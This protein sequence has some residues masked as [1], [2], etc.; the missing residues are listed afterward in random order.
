MQEIQKPGTGNQ[1]L[2]EEVTVTIKAAQKVLLSH[3]IQN[4]LW[5]YPAYLGQHFIYHY[6]LLLTWMGIKEPNLNLDFLRENVLKSQLADGSWHQCNDPALSEGDINVTIFNYWGLKATGEDIDSKPMVRARQFILKKGGVE[7]AAQFTKIILCLFQNLSWEVIPYSPY[8]IFFE[9][10]MMNYRSFSQ[11][12][13]PHMFGIAYMRRLRVS[14]DFGP[15]FALAEL[16][17]QP[18][19][20]LEPLRPVKFVD[21]YMVDKILVNQQPKGS[22]GGYTVATCFSLISLSNYA[23]N[24]PEEN[25]K[26]ANAKTKGLEMLR[27]LYLESGDGA[28][29]GHLMDSHYWDTMLAGLALVES[30]YDK[31]KLK[32]AADYIWDARNLENGG[33][34]FGFDFEYAPDIDDTSEALLFCKALNYREEDLK[35]AASW[36][37]EC[38]SDDGGWGAFDKNNNGN[39]LLKYF[40]KNLADS[41]ALFDYS[42]PDTTGN[43]MEAL[44]TMGYTKSNSATQRHA[45]KF[46]KGAQKADGS[47]FGRW[48]IN[49]I[50]GTCCAISGLIRAG[51]NSSEPYLQKSIHWFE[52]IQNSD[53]GWGESTRSYKEAEWIGKGISTP[54]QT[55]WALM[56]LIE[57][58]MA[59]TEMVKRGIRYLV[60]DFNSRGSWLDQATVGTGHPGL[61]YLEYPSYQHTFPLIAL[62]KFIHSQSY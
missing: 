42:S 2:H 6:Y 56:A 47:W 46:L 45:I 52:K 8:F 39:F 17:T 61:L 40:T 26:V 55:A 27:W 20:I 44:A 28:Y 13:V 37:I 36:I 51:E 9:K 53:G 5:D 25:A 29:K 21:G 1:D 34:P 14:K 15:K 43:A 50:F 10:M 49:H 58:G 54:S 57:C 18:L 22:W 35:R 30:G 48:A 59:N 7:K 11:W 24:H 12:V 33:I 38:Q 41:A 19:K 32:P 23:E 31:E 60:K 16:R 62:G 4:K 3:Q